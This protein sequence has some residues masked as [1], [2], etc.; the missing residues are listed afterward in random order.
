MSIRHRQPLPKTKLI[1]L[2]H[3]VD[4]GRCAIHNFFFPLLE[5]VGGG[6]PL[7]LLVTRDL[8]PLLLRDLVCE[9]VAGGGQRSVSPRQSSSFILL[10]GE[11]V[12]PLDGYTVGM[13]KGPGD[14]LGDGPGEGPGDGP[15]EGPGDGPGVES[16]QAAA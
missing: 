10:D 3:T 4:K 8:V 16:R 11:L 7:V 1:D 6:A 2:S 9:Y 13:G 14:G 15:G 12:G 5:G